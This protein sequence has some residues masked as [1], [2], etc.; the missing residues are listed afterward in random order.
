MSLRTVN[1][2]L[3]CRKTGFQTVVEGLHV[4]DVDS[5]EF[6]ITL[7]DGLKTIN[8][9]DYPTAAAIMLGTKPDGTTIQND[10]RIEGNKIIYDLTEQDT[11]EKG[12]VEYEVCLTSTDGIDAEVLYSAK[13]RSA[14]LGNIYVPKYRLLEEQPE[15]WQ[16]NYGNYYRKTSTG[17]EAVTD[18]SCPEYEDNT[19]YYLV[20]PRTESI[21]DYQ[22]FYKLYAYLR[23]TLDEIN[24]AIEN[25]AESEYVDTALAGKLT[26]DTTTETVNYNA[27]NPKIIYVNAIVN[28]EK[29]I[30]ITAN[31]SEQTQFFFGR[32]GTFNIRKR[33]GSNYSVW[34]PHFEKLSSKTNAITNSNKTSETLYPSIKAV[35]DYISSRVTEI[36]SYIDSGFVTT[37]KY[38]KDLSDINSE[39]EEKYIYDSSH[40]RQIDEC[41]E[42]DTIYR[43]DINHNGEYEY[44]LVVCVKDNFQNVTQYAFTDQGRF[45]C[46]K[47]TGNVWGGFTELIPDAYTKTEAGN[48]FATLTQLSGKADKANT[49]GGYNITDAYTKTQVDGL[50]NEYAGKELLFPNS[51]VYDNLVETATNRQLLFFG[52]V[53]SESSNISLNLPNL[54]SSDRDTVFHIEITFNE[55]SMSKVDFYEYAGNVSKGLYSSYNS[56]VDGYTISLDYIMSDRDVTTFRMKMYEVPG[57]KNNI[58]VKVSK[59]TYINEYAYSKG[60]VNRALEGKSDINHIHDMSTY[61]TNA[62]V[63][64]ALA[65]K[66]D[67]NHTHSQYLT[68]HQDISG[69]ADKATTLDGYGITDACSKG[70][71]YALQKGLLYPLPP[72]DGI[73]YEQTIT[74]ARTNARLLFFGLV[75]STGSVNKDLGISRLTSDDYGTVFH[76]EI[77]SETANLTSVRFEEVDSSNNVAEITSLRH[78]PVQNVPY[79]FDYTMS[80][81][82]IEVFRMRLYESAGE[83]VIKVKIT[84]DVNLA[85][86]TYS[87][88]EIKNELDTKADIGETL[89]DYGITNAYT[90]TEVDALLNKGFPP[91]LEA[92]IERVKTEVLTKANNNDVVF[93]LYTD[94]HFGN[95]NEPSSS[96]KQ[97]WNGI[98]SLRRLAD[99]C[100]LDF[101]MQGG[102]LLSQGLYNYDTKVLSRSQTEFIGCPVPLYTSKGDHDSNQTDIKISKS[103]FAERTAPYMPKAVKSSAYPNNFYFDLPEKKTRVINIDTGTVMVGQSSYGEDYKTW[104]NETLYDW[105]IDEVFTDEVKN[106]WKFIIFTHAPCDY[107][108]QF[109]NVKRYRNAHPTDTSSSQNAAKGNMLLINELM[110]A[111]N[112]ATTF[113]TEKETHRYKLV[114]NNAGVLQEANLTSDA[115]GGDV[116]GITG[117]YQQ[118]T[119]YPK[120]I[121][122]KDFSAW[123]SKAKMILSGH[124]HCDRLNK[125]TLVPD[126]DN[127]TRGITSYAIAYT[128]SAAR[129]GYKDEQDYYYPCFGTDGEIAAWG[130]ITTESRALGTVNEQLFDI[131]IVGDTYVKRVRFGAGTNSP[132]LST[133]VTI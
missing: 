9:S 103:D 91:Y 90:K 130:H 60:E 26:V 92:E 61:A 48:I 58:S 71:A 55:A 6:A 106:G 77:T 10:C 124:T 115:L 44:A 41:I 107:E 98:K 12:Y 34:E 87:K 62:S 74:T 35:V 82:N 75:T 1:I 5:C 4:G 119:G 8:L 93:G 21:N 133:T 28:G 37:S 23:N 117:L 126:G 33:T 68:Q 69:K 39:L 13:F 45:L 123:T 19:F 83:Q 25:K 18:V 96:L 67:I 70:Q 94:I 113:S 42:Q 108:W 20:N 17:F 22:A 50:I 120:Y 14:V 65:G 47:K 125:T 111:I 30:I 2:T 31:D 11:V 102:D 16:Q 3:N 64:T 78:S 24:N 38:N 81:S 56:I 128:G 54:T 52:P 43:A 7:L 88:E 66:S 76:F 79:K 131:W 118:T 114:H 86:Y 73:A 36:T 46:R 129:T 121:K 49:L 100:I 122:T 72:G 85:G 116:Y 97:K 101:V 112:S 63:G 40:T 51:V 127:Y 15:D 84:K 27:D 95:A 53:G 132:L 29:G 59:N 80:S 110:T 57:K 32:T 109:G 99:E 89:S 105:L 104:S